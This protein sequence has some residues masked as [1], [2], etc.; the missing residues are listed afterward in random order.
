MDAVVSNTVVDLREYQKERGKECVGWM[1]SIVGKKRVGG[2]K[3]C[4]V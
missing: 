4:F 3:G 1:D 2:W